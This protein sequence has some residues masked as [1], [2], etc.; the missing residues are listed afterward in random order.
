M[1]HRTMPPGLF[2]RRVL[3]HH[4]SAEGTCRRAQNAILLP[5]EEAIFV[6]EAEHT[7][8]RSARARSG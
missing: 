2:R 1:V 7:R 6:P 8:Q 5:R 4:E 3:M